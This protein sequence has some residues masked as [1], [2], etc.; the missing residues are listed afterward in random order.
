MDQIDQANRRRLPRPL[1]TR[2]DWRVPWTSIDTLV[3]AVLL[4]AF[5]VFC[6]LIWTWRP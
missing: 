5:C 1:L 4:A 6:W 3:C 2:D